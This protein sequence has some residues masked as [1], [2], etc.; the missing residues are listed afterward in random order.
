[1]AGYQYCRDVQVIGNRAYVA[2]DKSMRIFDVA[3]PLN[4]TSVTYYDTGVA[5]QSIAVVGNRIYLGQGSGTTQPGLRVF[6]LSAVNPD[7]FS[8]LGLL[9]TTNAVMRMAF[10]SNY[11]Y[12]YLALS[13]NKFAVADISDVG[14]TWSIAGTYTVPLLSG[15]SATAADITAA[16]S[17]V[18]L[19]IHYAGD[20]LQVVSVTDPT[21]PV[22]LGGYQAPANSRQAFI[23]GD[24]LYLMATN[25]L[26]I[27]QTTDSAY[28]TFLGK[29]LGEGIAN[30]RRIFA[31]GNR[32]YAL[33]Q[34]NPRKVL[35]LNTTAPAAVTLAG[36]YT[37]SRGFAGINS[38]HASGNTFYLLTLSG[39]PGSLQSL[40][41]IVDTAAAGGP[42]KVG[43]YSFPGEG[44]A[45][46]VAEGKAYVAYVITDTSGN[47]TEQ[48]IKVLDVGQ[49]ASPS[50]LGSTPVYGKTRALWLEGNT[51]FVGSNTGSFS[52]AAWKVEAFDV[53][54]PAAIAKKAETGGT[55][56]INGLE[57]RNGNLFA[58][59][60]AGSVFVYP[61][62]G[63]AFAS[64]PSVCHSPGTV[65][66][67]VTT[68]SLS[69]S[70]YV[71]TPEGHLY[72]SYEGGQNYLSCYGDKGITIQEYG[73]PQGKCCVT[74]AVAPQEAVLDECTAYAEPEGD[75]DC[76]TPVTVTAQAVSP[77]VFKEWTGATPKTS[78]EATAIASAKCS[79]ALATFWI[80]T[81]TL[82]KGQQNPAPGTQVYALESQ[83]DYAKGRKNVPIAQ[84]VL[85]VN[86]VD[87]W[88]I[89]TVSFETSGTGNEQEDV[90]EARLYVS[91]PNG[92]LLGSTAIGNDN[93]GISFALNEIIQKG[94]SLTLMLVYD[95]RPEKTFPCN[96]YTAQTDIGHI[97]AQPMNFPPGIK[98]PPLE[99]K[100]VGGPTSIRQGTLTI[101]PPE[102][103]GQY[104]PV[105]DPLNPGDPA[106]LT[107]PLRVRL[108]WQ[109]PASAKHI[110]YQFLP[111]THTF[112][113]FLGS[114]HGTQS[115][116]TVGA[117]GYAQET[118]TL[119]D[120]KGK[121]KPYLIQ[122]MADPVTTTCSYSEVSANFT[123]WGLG[124]GLA[125]ASQFDNPANGDTF[126]TFIS[127]IQADN[128]FTLTIDMA[129]PNYATVDEVI[130]ALGNQS[131][132]ATPVTPNVTYEAVFDMAAFQQ[133][134]KL[135]VT[136]KMTP[137]GGSQIEQTAEYDVKCLKLPGWVE[138]VAGICHPES[139][140]REFSSDDGGAY[141]F[142][143]NYPTNF[144]WT[145]YVPGDVG[146][147]GGLKNDLDIE[148][149]ASAS[150]KVDETSTFGATIKGKPV[151]LGKEFTLEGGLSGTFDPSFA[152][153]QGNGTLKA[154][155]SFDLPS[156]GFSKTFLVYGVPITAAVD[157]SGNVEIF[158]H[159]S[160]VLNKKLEFKEITVAPGTT[161]TGDVT[162][163]LSAVFGLAKIAAT[164]S[165]TA[166]VQIEVKYTTDSGTKTKWHGTLVVPIKVVGSIFWGVGKAE[167][168][169]TQLG[170]WSF[171]PGASA[172][173]SVPAAFRPLEVTGG[174]ESPRLLS[175]SALAID[176]QGRRMTLWIDDRTPQAPSPDPDVFFRF[177]DGTA[178][179]DG[180]P[181]IGAAA[182][183][184]EWEMDPAV[185]FLSGG[186]ALGCWTANKGD[187]SLGE[188]PNE[189]GNPKLDAILAGQD[190]ACALWNG[191]AWSA[192][193]RIIDDDQADGTV[194]LAYDAGAGKA[195]AVWVHNA[196][197]DRR[198]MQRTAWQL[199]YSLFDPAANEGAG[200]FTAPA[201][202]PGTDTGKADQMPAIATDGAGNA[203]LVWARDDD[204]QFHTELG[205]VANGTNVDPTNTD[206]HILWSRWTGAGWT[207]PAAIAT[208][209]TATKLSPA[210]AFA[211]GGTALAAWTEKEAVEGALVYRLK[212][213]I[214]SAGSW[215]TPALVTQSGQYIEDPR[216]VVD[217]TGKATVLWRGY[218]GRS[219][220]GA[221][222]SSSGQMPNPVW[223]EPK[224]ITHDDTTQWQADAAVDGSGK[225]YTV[226]SAYHPSSGAS[227]S[228][229]GFGSG[230]NVAQENPASASII[231][232][233]SAEVSDYDQN[234]IYEDLLV[235]VVVDVA[236]AG[237]YEV[238]ADL[239]SGT[240]FVASS[241][242]TQNVLEGGPESFVLLFAGAIIGD[243]GYDGPY[244]L[245]N[246]VV[247]DLNGSPVQ[248]AFAAA[249]AFTT[250]AYAAASFVPGPLA[251]D[252]GHYLGTGGQAV[253]TLTDPAR[254]T[255]AGLV[256]SL[257]VRVAT[258]RDSEGILVTLTETAA[259][260][261]IFQGSCG[262]TLA[263]SSTSPAKILVSDHDLIQVICDD[264]VRSYTWVRTA[265]WTIGGAGDV[266]GDG[267]VTLAD[268][269]LL[270]KI[271]A[272]ITP[273]GAPPMKEADVNS[274]D[275]I[276]AQ[277][278]LFILQV[279]AGLR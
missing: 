202:V 22:K 213:A 234:G 259:N 43:E 269:I 205:G 132:T 79:Q 157:L 150:Y 245:R 110:D 68:P 181:L 91:D 65:G 170:P 239:Y 276:G 30:A 254:N 226:W 82:G 216:A 49:P 166:T 26:W 4:P 236:G 274:D 55:S 168:Y 199:R 71:Y 127:N 15:E 146:L 188:G 224:Q 109:H 139:F 208:G 278:V 90:L 33:L 35:I 268:A 255:D 48:G 257:A 198:A 177:H 108:G 72:E 275:K 16:G 12:A 229:A 8:D 253:I 114:T 21:A 76:R 218:T 38:L 179:T 235:T 273:T 116:Q 263:S 23:S 256:Q 11:Q 73:T 44:R 223:S 182:T 28:P 270:L 96:S 232:D 115:Q 124:V 164:G 5:T 248:A 203:L 209:G 192:P 58:G 153:Q 36:T 134:Q 14:G 240:R 85:S 87:D 24:R 204:G 138:V 191:S 147:L 233:Y 250:A 238:R 183:N 27:Y 52:T 61:Y 95:F 130:F 128:K 163:S 89:S 93:A 161:V 200:A 140:V 206:S 104:G 39:S 210:I 2:Q 86:E 118:A 267:T 32:V 111:P 149:T 222:F 175:T 207:A 186:A 112:K 135:L 221:L 101:D 251:L 264:P 51:L 169:T 261:G 167:L 19:A 241:R 159:G 262:F 106:P 174:P 7:S 246:V 172:G 102:G 62:D 249:P 20:A 184:L 225:V 173:A 137:Q 201:V 97:G 160:A 185:A 123:A 195:L 66:I 272:G 119:G 9:S 231:D 17:N 25:G 77:W 99:V 78:P 117:D 10:S 47:L 141:N 70:G 189:E 75:V 148:F 230:V 277:E 54:N 162:I 13:T 107:N 64:T 144:A 258:T 194:R 129:P 219:G 187:K 151:I 152:F 214:F 197:P 176:G 80:P 41:E 67:A 242:L 133:P 37:T 92:R 18:F 53:A 46:W 155:F 63:T 57:V 50:L 247:M 122:A 121:N 34:T 59:V 178:W 271:G 193:V 171:P 142:T 103:D 60:F 100:M 1:V 156:K 228:G 98:Y 220:S 105:I 215:T 158:I 84:I 45:V 252:K 113:G 42:A 131:I 69:G 125:T 40:L 136:V 74:T 237:S 217:A 29:Y 31:E 244:S 83:F 266:N 279:A 260:S 143:F 81:L 88:K 3:D 94:Q 56:E 126:G 6:Q 190:I 165:P 145:D 227:Q 196:D 120:Q 243:R 180:A 154:S 211:P 212:Y 265:T